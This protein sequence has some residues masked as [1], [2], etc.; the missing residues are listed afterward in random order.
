MRCRTFSVRLTLEERALLRSLGK[1][2]ERADGDALRQA[3]FVAARLHDL[4]PAA[5]TPPPTAPVLDRA[6]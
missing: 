4:L 1:R 3:L 2:L 6:A 5:T